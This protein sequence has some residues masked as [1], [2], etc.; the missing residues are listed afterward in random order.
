MQFPFGQTVIRERRPQIED[1]HDPDHTIAGDWSDVGDDDR[2][3]LEQAFVAPSSSAAA[4]DATRTQVL[5]TLSLYLTDPDAD[6]L[7][8][9]RIIAAGYPPLYINARPEATQSPFTGWRPIVEIPL[10]LSEG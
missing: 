9:D 1:P 10:D 2:L 3:E 8:G 5:T 4:G 7:V 6:V